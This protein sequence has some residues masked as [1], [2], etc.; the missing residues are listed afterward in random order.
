MHERILISTRSHR[1][2]VLFAWSLFLVI[3]SVAGCAHYPV[4]QPLDRY[5]PGSGYRET[6][7]GVPGNSDELLLYL[8]LLPVFFGDQSK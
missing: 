7:M 5:D 8:T 4:N 2:H 1:E 3:M 6:F